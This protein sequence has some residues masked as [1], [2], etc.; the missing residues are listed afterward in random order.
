[1]YGA[2]ASGSPTD[3]FVLRRNDV[4]PL[5]YYVLDGRVQVPTLSTLT[6]KVLVS[7]GQSLAGNNSSGTY[8][9]VNS[10]NHNFCYFNGA[11]YQSKARLL[12]CDDSMHQENFLARLADKIITA[13]TVQ[14]V[15]LCP[16]NS[17]GTVIADWIPGGHS[18]HW[19]T[20]MC[21]RLASVGL[22]PDAVM[23]SLG[24]SDAQAG[25]SQATF[26]AGMTA[27]IATFTAGGVSCP[28]YLEKCTW[29]AGSQ[30]AGAAAIRAAIDALVNG[31]TIKAGPDTD[32]LNN[33][34]RQDTTHWN[35]T[36]ADAAAA[37]W[38]TALGM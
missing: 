34:N 25:T 28:H 17:D 5:G 3:P 29:I 6:N 7:L 4:H 30:P 10:T 33:T 37:L 31:T 8:S 20:A 38:K 26:Q 18:N 14:R 13:G 21:N 16:M 36:G 27:A 22:V 12:G 15:V 32:T 2:G 23:W 9:I 11:T 1:M 19:I 35:A 24:E